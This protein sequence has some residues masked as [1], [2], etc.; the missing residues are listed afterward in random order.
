MTYLWIAY[1]LLLLFLAFAHSKKFLGSRMHLFRAFL[2]SW[3][4]FDDSDRVPVLQVRI[5]DE[6]QGLEKTHWEN[7]MSGKSCRPWLRLFYNPQMNYR[8]AI[9][10]LLQQICQD[11]LDFSPQE[12]PQEFENKPTYQI[13]KNIVQHELQKRLSASS[14]KS[15]YFQFRILACQP[16]IPWTPVDDLLISK[17]YKM[18]ILSSKDTE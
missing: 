8:L 15:V 13:L 5:S 17:N 6:A 16:D 10:S 9:H 1:F 2:P 3:K 12:K 7:L 18:K 4:F 14:Y 11:I